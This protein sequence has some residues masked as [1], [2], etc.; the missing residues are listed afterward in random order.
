M[1]QL[2]LPLVLPVAIAF[3]SC[4]A[5]GVDGVNGDAPVAPMAHDPDVVGAAVPSESALAE[6]WGAVVLEYV[7]LRGALV[8]SDLDAARAKA[9][10]LAARL[11]PA[12]VPAAD[13]EAWAA[14]TE[15][16]AGP[17]AELAEA[18][19]LD[20]ARAAFAALTD[21]V[22][23]AVRVLGDGGRDL[24]VQ[25]CPMAFDNAGASWVSAEREI[26][27]PYFGDAMLTCGRVTEEL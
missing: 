17:A 18:A 8:A 1:K 3:A 7:A 4:G 10:D 16:L 24:F 9:A 5:N 21:P 13:G 6:P 15:P 2:A 22:V 26:R 11:D 12:D 23:A 14:A 25:H 20:A 19:D 27:N